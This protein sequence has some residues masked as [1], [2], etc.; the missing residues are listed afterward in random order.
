M[1]LGCELPGRLD[2]ISDMFLW[3]LNH[4]SFL[5]EQHAYRCTV[6]SVNRTKRSCH[7]TLHMMI[8]ST[9]IPENLGT[10]AVRTAQLLLN[11]Y[12]KS[13]RSLLFGNHRLFLWIS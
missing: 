8:E 3:I 13:S 9:Y 10:T 7:S 6:S 5:Y 1:Y 12:G 4:L 2:T 11:M